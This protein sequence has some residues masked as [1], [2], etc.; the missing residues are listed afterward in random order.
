MIYDITG[1][2]KGD[3]LKKDYSLEV[4]Y[5]LRIKIRKSINQ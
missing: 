2:R 1:S 4:Y 3:K 5:L